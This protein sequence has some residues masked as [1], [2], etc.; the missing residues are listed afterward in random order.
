MTAPWYLMPPMLAWAPGRRVPVSAGRMMHVRFVFDP[1]HLWSRIHAADIL[2][3]RAEGG[4]SGE[5][6]AGV[7]RSEHSSG[8]RSDSPDLYTRH[9]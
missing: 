5:R 9:T 1:V 2:A 3:A 7:I 8:L 4:R 6:P